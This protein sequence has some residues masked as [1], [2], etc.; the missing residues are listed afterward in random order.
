MEKNIISFLKYLK[1][2]RNYS[3]HTIINYGKDLKVFLT[4]LNEQKINNW[5]S[6]SYKTIRNFLEFLY[7]LDY[8]KKSVARH[9]SSLRSLY[10]YLLK[11]NIVSNNP[12]VLVSNPKLDQKLPKFLYYDELEKILS[13]P[14]KTTLFGM[15][16]LTILET[17]YSTGIR[18]S[19][20]TNI[21]LTD[22]DFSNRTIKILGK[23]NKERYVLFGDVLK[24]YLKDY[25][26]L[27]NEIAKCDY[28]FINKYGNG[29]TDRGVRSII[30]NILKKGAI[31]YHISP[32]TL[33]HTFA[34]HLLDNGADLR[35]VQELLGHESLS[36]TQVYT[37]VSN[38]H[39][40]EVYLNTHPRSGK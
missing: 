39:L 8:S 20:L 15:R 24:S 6:I 1:L 13:I 5:E 10:K 35:V 9:I 26:S 40:R 37:H 25:L 22:I 2:E 18:V 19:E 38:E 7:E 33:R 11:E 27:R 3:N 36:S 17:F 14:D 12:L 31:S 30:E 21:K 4:F 16:D 29:L 34:T 28:L 23:G 32:H